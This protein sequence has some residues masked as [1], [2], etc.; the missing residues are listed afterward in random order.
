MRVGLAASWTASDDESDDR[1][2]DGADDDVNVGVWVVADVGQVSGDN[3]LVVAGRRDIETVHVRPIDCKIPYR[4]Y[5]SV[6][7]VVDDCAG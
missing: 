2:Y 7:V 4:I 6:V 1:W 5:V 3:Q